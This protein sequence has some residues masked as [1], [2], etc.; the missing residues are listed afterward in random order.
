[1]NRIALAFMT[2]DLVALSRQTIKP[3]LGLPIDLFWCDGSAGAEGRG[4]PHAISLEQGENHRIFVHGNVL[5]GP[6]AAVAYA[7]TAMLAGGDYD[8]VGIVENDVLLHDGWF[9]AA[10]ALFERGAAE[11]LTVGA[12]SARAYDD[13][14]LIQRDGFAVMHNLGFGMHILTREAAQIALRNFRTGWTADNRR[15]FCQLTEIDIGTYWAFRAQDH[16]LCSDWGQ[17][18]VLAGHGLASLALTPSLCEMIGQNPP[19][20]DQGLKLV[21]APVED[22]RDDLAFDKYVA[23]TAAIRAGSLRP[24]T[25]RAIYR[26]DDGHYLFFPHQLGAIDAKFEGDWRLK[27]TQGFGPF[28]WR[29]G[30]VREGYRP[31]DRLEPPSMEYKLAELPHFEHPTLTVTISGPCEFMIAGGEK[32]GQ[33]IVEDLKSGYSVKPMLPPGDQVMSLVAPCT[34]SHRP[35]RL[36]MLSPGLVFHALRCRERQPMRQDW[37][38]DHSVLPPV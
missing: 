32:G 6:D 14:V 4:L 27:W 34:V 11:G 31:P 26:G 15:L 1:M 5:G 38:F 8:Y 28:G 23:R 30:V 36:T 17:D 13:R 33:V 18:R 9:E 35:V 3:L 20:A 12:V 10:M 29:A 22:R 2:R 16:Q 7:Y 25:T 24:G 37:S 21:E 19:L